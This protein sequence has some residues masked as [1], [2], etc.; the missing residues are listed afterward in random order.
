MD[1]Y[2]ITEADWFGICLLAGLGAMLLGFL[3]VR[4]S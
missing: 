2:Y 1:A 4:L 3:L